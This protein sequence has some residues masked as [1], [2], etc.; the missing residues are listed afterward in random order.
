LFLEKKKIKG[1]QM[2]IQSERT[3]LNNISSI[4]TSF[5][6]AATAKQIIKSDSKLRYSKDIIKM[7][8][9]SAKC[10]I[11]LFRY[12]VSYAY[13]IYTT[14][15]DKL[16]SDVIKYCNCLEVNDIIKIIT[17]I[18]ANRNNIDLIIYLNNI[19]NKNEN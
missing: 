3:D 2:E 1:K 16:S 8:S 18:H 12:L 11:K 13:H 5:M 15:Y 6:A 17:F 4:M 14:Q 7:H 9:I 19:G 10:D